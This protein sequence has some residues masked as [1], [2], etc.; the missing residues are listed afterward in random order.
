MGTLS[1]EAQTDNAWKRS[2]G[3]KIEASKNVKRL[4]FP[5]KFDLYDLNISTVREALFSVVDKS[6]KHSVIISLPN[7]KGELEQFEMYE[8]SNFE[9][10]LQAKY[11]QIRAFSGKGITDRYATIK[12]SISPQGIQTMVFRTDNENEFMEPYSVDGKT[13]AVFNSERERGR[14]SWTCSTDDHGMMTSIDKQ[15]PN[16]NKSS[17]GQLKT[18]RLA[19][20]C[21]GEY[22]AYFGASTA[23]NDADKAIVLAA[24]NATLS[25]CN[26]VYEKDLALHLN[27]VASTTNVIY[28]NPS[29]DPYSANLGQWN[30]QLQN[31]LSNNLTGPSTSLAANNAAYDIG[32]MFGASGGGGNAGCIGCVC[33]DDTDSTSD[34]NKGAGITSPADGVPMGD[35]FDID[36]VVHEVGHQLGGNHTFSVDNEGAGV[37][38]EVGSGVT[39]MGY[40]GITD[41]DVAPHSIAIYHQASIA[42][43]QANLAGKSCPVTTS[44]AGNNATPVANA[45]P[46]YTIPKSTPF[47]LTGSATDANAGDAL[48]Y[49]WEQNDDAGSLTAGN[50]VASATKTSGP[51]WRSWNPTVSPFRY[52]PTLPS[53]IANRTTTTGTG[54]DGIL[55]EA[56]SS[57][58]RTLNFRLTVRDNAPYSS[59]APITVGQTSYDDMRVTVSSAAG[60]FAV[61]A[62]NAALSWA[63]GTN[64]NVTWNVSGTTANGINCNYVDIYLS[65]DG[66]NTYSIL[67]ASKVPN[68]GTE[69]IT[70]PN[71]IGT[72]NRIMVRGNNHIFFDIS[73]VNF[74]IAAP[75]SS[76]S[77]AFNGV[78]GQ[79]F[80]S[81]CKGSSVSYTIDYKAFGGFSGT[82]TFTSAGKPTGST[83][84]FSPTTMSSTNGTVTMT[85]SN[86]SGSPVGISNIIVTATSG[87]T[88]KKVSYYLDLLNSTFPAMTLNA[89]A[90]NAVGQ[91]LNLNL[92]WAANTNASSYDVQVATDLAFTNIISSGNTTTTS[93]SLSGLSEATNYY[94]RVMPK[95]AGCSGTYSPVFK[96]KTG[97]LSCATTNSTNVPVAI[98]D[99]GTGTSTIV[100]ANGGTIADV[101]ITLNASHDWIGDTVGRLTSPSG[102]VVQLFS[103]PCDNEATN[104]NINAT[105]DDAGVTPI[106]PGITGTVIPAQALSAF[107]GQ[108]STGT[109][110][111]RVIDQATNDAGTINSWSLNI[112]TVQTASVADNNLKNFTIYPNPN[113]GNF[114][115][116]FE[117]NSSNNIKINVYDISGR[118]IFE[119]SY[120]NSGF[121]NQ[122]IQL[123][124][125]QTGVYLITVLDGDKQT[126]K[127]IVIK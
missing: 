27:L 56:L 53:I 99:N 98:P 42:Q 84:T 39:I 85:V 81:A 94:W 97:V 74:T 21:N 90:N 16:T 60:P 15:I 61:T 58:A 65:T 48:T 6:S 2:S 110:T 116:Q 20:S 105:F 13:Y 36:Y 55:V 88:S 95:N 12:L 73:N 8:A 10:D 62:P 112:C 117:S 50:S 71:N 43:I 104:A 64:Q 118:I 67:L 91:S 101:N 89:P 66:G 106:C 100:I 107:N 1:A 46:D 109:W 18:M 41:Q 22:A 125:A 68:D 75:T 83:V 33:V 3:E 40:A 111:L 32:H 86:T 79:Q 26:G 72:T 25:R 93:Y 96:F 35:N 103:R 34:Q 24:F 102:T 78:A 121:F 19:Q 23:G 82:T 49:C 7:T 29:T 14:L 124:N 37:N 70:V 59:S 127:R 11:P 54:N 114:N 45:G 120:Q 76:F 30:A 17:A 80:K 52:M 113:N 87:A 28:C 4:S 51:N 123:N 108:N 44:L 122:N 9:Q 57:V 119:K 77:V 5:K 92:T 115:V 47:I 38:K 31:T 69:T 63:V 126:T